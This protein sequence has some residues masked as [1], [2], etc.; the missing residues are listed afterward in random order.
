MERTTTRQKQARHSFLL[1]LIPGILKQLN[2]WIAKMTAFVGLRRDE[3]GKGRLKDA[4]DQLQLLNEQQIAEGVIRLQDD[5]KRLR[6]AGIIDHQ[7][8][9]IASEFPAEMKKGNSEVV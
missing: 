9:R 5:L 7:G 2:R 6:A 1:L 3:S 4:S 8:K